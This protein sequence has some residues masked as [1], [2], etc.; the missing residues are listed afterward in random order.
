MSDTAIYRDRRGPRHDVF[1]QVIWPVGED[2]RR[3]RAER[4]CYS[5]QDGDGRNHKRQ[6]L[7]ELI[8]HQ[9]GSCAPAEMWVNPD[10]PGCGVVKET[11]IQ[12]ELNG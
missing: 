12:G 11:V 8:H 10:L 7:L 5:E 6:I 9:P 4:Y 3:T 1:V 2:S